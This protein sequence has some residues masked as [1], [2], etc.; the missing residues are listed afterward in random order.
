M[1]ASIVHP[2][3]SFSPMRSSAQVRDASIAAGSEGAGDL[4]DFD[5]ASAVVAGSAGG[6]DVC[7]CCLKEISRPAEWEVVVLL[8]HL[9][10]IAFACSA[11]MQ[12]F[13]H[14]TQ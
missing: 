10:A 9:S 6:G 12:Y 1:S 7:G 4:V 13:S 11:V 5:G 3:K 14:L 8:S 2:S